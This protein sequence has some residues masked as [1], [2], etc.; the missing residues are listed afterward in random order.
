MG[1]SG[2]G[3]DIDGFDK[4]IG[5]LRQYFDD[6]S[7]WI[8]ADHGNMDGYKDKFSYGF[9]VYTPAIQMTW[10]NAM[11]TYRISI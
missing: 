1:R 3:G 4:C 2:Y 5:M 10:L 11:I 6:D 7:I 9:D 8:S